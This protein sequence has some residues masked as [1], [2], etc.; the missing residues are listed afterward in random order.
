MSNKR[1]AI[2]L[3]GQILIT[4]MKKQIRYIPIKI[5]YKQLDLCLHTLVFKR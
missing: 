3:T 1:N 5:T 2:T 4:H